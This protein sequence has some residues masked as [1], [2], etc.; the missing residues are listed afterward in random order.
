[1]QLSFVYFSIDLNDKAEWASIT[2][3][4]KNG[5]SKI[6]YG[7]YPVVYSKTFNSV[8]LNEGCNGN[9]FLTYVMISSCEILRY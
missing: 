2:T 4:Y 6:A 1:M 7:D 3:G 9:V 5:H 8:D